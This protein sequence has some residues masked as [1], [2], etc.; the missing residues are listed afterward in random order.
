M[1]GRPPW[2]VPS[3]KLHVSDLPLP[4]YSQTVCK[5][6]VK[7]AVEELLFDQ[8]LDDDEECGASGAALMPL[9]VTLP[10]TMHPYLHQFFCFGN[11]TCQAGRAFLTSPHLH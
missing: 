7:E 6:Y 2:H 8:P 1:G 3:M 9:C 11:Q 5:E 4:A 10:M